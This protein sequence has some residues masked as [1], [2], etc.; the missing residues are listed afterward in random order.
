[1]ERASVEIAAKRGR[2]DFILHIS[3]L[4]DIENRNIVPSL[5][6]LY[7]VSVIYHLSAAEISGWYEAPFQQ[8][9][10]EGTSFPAPRTHLS[11]FLSP[12]LLGTVHEGRQNSEATD[13]LNELP[14]EI[15]GIAGM[16]AAAGRYRYGYTGLSDRRMIPILRPGSVVLVDTWSCRIEDTDWKNE[17]ERPIYFVELHEG[18]RCRWFDKSKN[19]LTMQSHTLSHCA[20]ETWETRDDAELVG[21]MVGMATHLSETWSSERPAVRG[22]RVDLNRTSL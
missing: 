14:T 22:G 8:T 4:A 13:L 12:S 16:E 3:R 20:P 19:Q 18:Y 10:Q 21:K 9:F 15:G 1:M 2:A 7:S 11:E 17:Y 6:K 5:Y